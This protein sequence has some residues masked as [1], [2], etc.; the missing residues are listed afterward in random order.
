MSYG[1]IFFLEQV[2]GISLN[3]HRLYYNF[4][5]EKCCEKRIEIRSAVKDREFI[6]LLI[7]Y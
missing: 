6:E 7:D 3:M 5:L 2:C 4:C 1:R